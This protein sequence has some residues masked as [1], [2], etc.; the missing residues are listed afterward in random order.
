MAQTEDYG[1][2]GYRFQDTAVQPV[3]QLFAV[4]YEKMTDPSYDWDGMKRIDGPLYLFQYTVSGCGNIDIGDQTCSV[5]AGTAFMVE[6]PGQHRYYLPSSSSEWEFYFILFRQRYL[7]E[8]WAE[9]IR[10]LSPLP[11]LEAGSAPIRMLQL[12]Y[13]EARLGRIQDSYRASSLVY[14]FI[15]ELSRSVSAQ[16]KERGG[17]PDKVKLA[18][19]H[20]ELHYHL[21]ESLD[22]IAAAAGSSKFHLTRTFTEATGMTPIAYLTKLRMERAVELLRKSTLTVDEI[23]RAVGYT[24]GSYF[25]KVF[26]SWV[27][28]PPGEFRQAKELPSIDRFIFD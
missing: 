6:I 19:N 23:A 28:F 20:M 18:A 27:G 22:T 25:S 16:R 24:S 15:M 9:L 13:S 11:E 2:Y 7:A 10:T 14:Q 21:S 4:G 17:W 3:Y 8:L 1:V 12:I 5:P 26:R